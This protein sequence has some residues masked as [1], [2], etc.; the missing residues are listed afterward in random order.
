MIETQALSVLFVLKCSMSALNFSKASDNVSHTQAVRG[1]IKI[2]YGDGKKIGLVVTTMY[3]TSD[4]IFIKY[5][6]LLVAYLFTVFTQD[7]PKK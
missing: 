2:K 6:T 5:W 3:S 4:M 7:L 1:G